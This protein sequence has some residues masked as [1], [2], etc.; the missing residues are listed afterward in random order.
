MVGFFAQAAWATLN[1]SALP[2]WVQFDLHQVKYLG[3]I[4]AAFILMEASFRPIMG[5]LSDKLGRK[6]IILIGPALGIF[7]SI[8]TIYIR[9][10]VFLIPLRAFDG[11]GLAGFWPAG[12][13]MIGDT[14]GEERRSTATSVL[15]GS[16]MAGIAL[17]WLAGGLVND[18]THTLSGA[19]FFV[20]AMFLV[21]VVS[22]L[23]LLPEPAHKHLHSQVD[24]GFMRIW[25]KEEVLRIIRLVP[26]MLVLNLFVFFAVGLLMPIFK[27]YAVQEYHLTETTIGVIVAPAALALGLIAVPLGRLSDKWGMITSVQYGI[28]L[29]AVGMW[30]IAMS[31]SFKTAAAAAVLIGVGFMAAYPAWM[32]LVG[33]S[34]APNQRGKILGAVGMAEGIGAILGVLIGPLIYSSNWD[35]FP[36]LNITHLNAS[37]YLAAILL[38]IA[39]VIAFTWVY[40]RRME[41]ARAN[42][43]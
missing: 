29:C 18:L 1:F 21:T 4:L 7:T 38:S 35:P 13:A 20:S 43:T 30:V 15:N 28:A 40:R 36:K 19:F 23:L 10:A 8:L 24:E 39:A 22:G 31:G 14:F 3:F 33:S 25:N 2:M 27:L 11:I 6:P 9:N 42:N 26:D 41:T 34:A 32:A 12:Y 16:G 17:G 5:S 37:F